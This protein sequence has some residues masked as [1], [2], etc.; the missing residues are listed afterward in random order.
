M[1]TKSKRG[2]GLSKRPIHK[3]S[4]GIAI[5]EFPDGASTERIP[6]KFFKP[7]AGVYIIPSNLISF[8]DIFSL[9]L[10]KLD[11]FRGVNNYKAFLL[12]I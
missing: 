4:S 11:I 3:T 2:R 1:N 5:Y 10:G 7:I 6:P 12:Q 8:R 9:K